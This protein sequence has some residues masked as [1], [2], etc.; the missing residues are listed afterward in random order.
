MTGP[1]STPAPLDG[2][3]DTAAI[4][5]WLQGLGADQGVPMLPGM[6]GQEIPDMPD[7]LAVVTE[8]SGGP[9]RMEGLE[10]NPT[11]Q[12]R[13]RGRQGDALDAQR[14]ALAADRLIVFAPLPATVAG[15]RVWSVWRSGGRP[16]A[17]LPDPSPGLRPE[18]QCTYGCSVQMLP[19]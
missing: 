18:S 12:L 9:L 4:I 10:D 2:V 8:T 5:S 6:V 7:R 11:F 14:L 19:S 13:F 3:F 1:L 17:L 16:T 15:L